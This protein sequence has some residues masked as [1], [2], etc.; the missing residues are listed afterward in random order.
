LLGTGSTG[1]P[2][3]AGNLVIASSGD[4]TIHAFDARTGSP[5]WTLPPDGTVP[6]VLRGPFPRPP[7][8]SGPDYRPLARSDDLLFAGSLT[9]DVVAY[10]LSTRRE[11]WRHLDGAEGSVAF[12]LSSDRRSV[13]V[14][15]ASGRHVALAVDTGIPRWRT[16]A[17]DKGFNWPSLSIDT[18]VF[19][20]GRNGGFVAL[21]Q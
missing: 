5:A 15:F 18:R 6:P 8:S 11:R 20:A 17:M 1:G 4:G 21:R 9:G 13:Y 19:M 14:P 12:A 10:D 7:S 3:F 2:I 16:D